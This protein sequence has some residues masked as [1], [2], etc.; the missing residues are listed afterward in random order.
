MIIK[1]LLALLF[2]NLTSIPLVP[3]KMK[4]NVSNLNNKIANIET[5][6]NIKAHIEKIHQLSNKQEK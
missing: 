1:I 3:K 6:K 5:E 4:K 2:I